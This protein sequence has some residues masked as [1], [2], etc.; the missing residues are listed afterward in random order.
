MFMWK[1]KVIH[2]LFP[3]LYTFLAAEH[4][5]SNW[6]FSVQR[7]RMSDAVRKLLSCCKDLYLL[8]KKS[9]HFLQENELLFRGFML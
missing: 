9:L 1:R 4:F 6:H 5:L 2:G 3:V 8:Q 7:T